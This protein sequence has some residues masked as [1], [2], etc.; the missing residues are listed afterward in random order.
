MAAGTTTKAILLAEPDCEVR[1]YLET[2]FRCN[3]Y[4]V[5]TARSMFEL[6]GLI[7][8]SQRPASAIVLDAG[9]PGCA[10]DSFGDL[11]R[12]EPGIPLILTCGQS[13]VLDEVSALATQGATELVS[14]GETLT[15]FWNALVPALER[16]L[17]TAA[18]A[19][20]SGP[21]YGV[22][23]LG[24]SP[25]MR[26][27]HGMLDA[28]AASDT[29]LLIQ[30]ETGTGKEVYAREVHA[31]SP[32]SHRPLYKLN[33]AA[34]PS[35]LVESELFGYERGAFTGAFQRK[36]GMFDVADHATL[37]LD[38][39]GDMDVRLQ[40]KLLQILQDQT[41]QRLGGRELIRVNVRI[42]AATHRNLERAIAENRFREDLYYRLNVIKI[43]IPPLRERREDICPMAEYLLRKHADPGSTLPELSSHF[44]HRLYE[45]AWP[46][47]VRELENMMRNFLILRDPELI[48]RELADRSRPIFPAGAPASPSRPA[49]L[50]TRGMTRLDNPSVRHPTDE[51]PLLRR[52]ARAKREAETS[53]IVE[54][55]SASSWNRRRAAT[56]LGI[57]YKALL[58]KM[59]RLG[60][61]KEDYPAG[62]EGAAPLRMQAAAAAPTAPDARE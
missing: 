55:L 40:A 33:C 20:Q 29:S 11:L 42:L 13:Q 37:L 32:R 1:K 60:I 6:L 51:E 19:R 36:P 4:S 22:F 14:K 35:E 56:Q 10:A 58:Y 25:G 7:R 53:A 3:G 62:G 39:I 48:C 52:V 47:N 38:E 34:L 44:R 26:R 23:W 59:K 16:A 2:A 54:A 30:G 28:I 61:R 46:G 18:N 17:S 57:D 43:R 12:L 41:F 31:R 21:G 24:E 27:L 15:D 9:L 49:D 50:L 8:T 45:H 5:E